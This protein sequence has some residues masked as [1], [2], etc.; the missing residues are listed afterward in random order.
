MS[1]VPH[2]VRS[3]GSV[4]AAIVAIAAL[5]C[6]VGAWLWFRSPPTD[7]IAVSLDDPFD[8]DNPRVR[9]PGYLGPHACAPCHRERVA[10]FQET[11]HFRACRLP[12]AGTMPAG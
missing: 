7:R 3:R 8:D 1:R 6:V 11:T 5:G 4:L 2:F 12:E 10:E 9:N